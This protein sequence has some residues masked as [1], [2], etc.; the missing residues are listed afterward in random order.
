MPLLN[1]L[2]VIRDNIRLTYQDFRKVLFTMITD[3]VIEEKSIN[4]RIELLK[5]SKDF[6]A[7]NYCH[8]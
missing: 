1:K 3:F 6:F 7:K 8:M 2:M 5:G 4:G